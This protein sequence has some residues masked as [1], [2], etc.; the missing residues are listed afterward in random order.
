[1]EPNIN[2]YQAP[3]MPQMQQ[4]STPNQNIITPNNISSTSSNNPNNNESNN[5]TNVQVETLVNAMTS[6][7]KN[8][9]C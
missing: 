3:Q 2:Q 6:V 7:F 5:K 1:M 8:L 4:E 9:N